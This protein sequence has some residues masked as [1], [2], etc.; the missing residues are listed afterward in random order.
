MTKP[1]TTAPLT[2][3]LA[4]LRARTVFDELVARFLP[5]DEATVEVVEV[6]VALLCPHGGGDSAHVVALAIDDDF[7][8]L[9]IGQLVH[10][11]G[12]LVIGDEEIRQRNLPLLGDLEVDEE[13]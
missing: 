5:G 3:L 12:G 8:V 13:E 9:V 1:P 7:R 10:V 2:A 6:G 11:P 4:A